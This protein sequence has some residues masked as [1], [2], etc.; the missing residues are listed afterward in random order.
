LTEQ[1]KKLGLEGIVAKRSTSIYIPGREAYEWQKHR[2][3]EEGT[4]Y[5]GG[6]IPGSQGIGELLIGEFR[7]PGKQ[8]ISSRGSSR[9]KQIQ[10]AS[11][12]RCRAGPKDENVPLVNL[13]EK[14]TE[15]QYAVTIAFGLDRNSHAN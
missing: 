15:H 3:N 2:F 4:F 13:P 10:S 14:A 11:N 5:I 1:V 6:H 8:L 12:L 9:V 7:P